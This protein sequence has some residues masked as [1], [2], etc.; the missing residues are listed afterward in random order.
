MR[1]P[2]PDKTRLRA[3]VVAARRARTESE[4]AREAAAITTTA[5][6]SP[7]LR[8]ARTVTSYLSIGTEPSTTELVRTLRSRGVQVLMPV[9]RDD[10]DLDW[11]IY[12]DPG[13]LSPGPRGLWT[14]DGPLLGVEAVST[15]DL[16]I[17]PAIAVG[18]D[19]TRLGRGGGSYDRALARVPS[20]RPV[21]A[22]LYAGEVL[23]AVPA[24][25]HDRPVTAAITPDGI[26][27]FGP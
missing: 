26:H 4:R 11:A 27:R 23:A 14:V 20:G 25:P 8:A 13:Q 10:L 22:L 3:R 21:L 12:D 16:M 24:E 7:E 5:L 18:A 1:E 15:A 19:G 2:T 17:V 6:T 9:L